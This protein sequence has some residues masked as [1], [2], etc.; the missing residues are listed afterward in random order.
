MSR[1]K[2]GDFV[3]IS[4]DSPL[5]GFKAG[6]RLKILG[7]PYQGTWLVECA[8]D[9]RASASPK[10]CTLMEESELK[11]LDKYSSSEPTVN[12]EAAQKIDEVAFITDSQEIEEALADSV[13]GE[14]RTIKYPSKTGTLS[15]AQ[16]RSAV[17]VVSE[18][19]SV[20]GIL[21]KDELSWPTTH[22]VAT[23]SPL[24]EVPLP[25]FPG[26]ENF[27]KW[28]TGNGTTGKNETPVGVKNDE[29]KPRAG[30]VLEGF[31]L[32]LKGV[33]ESGTLGAIEYGD[34]NWLIVP[35]AKK[36]FRDAMMRHYLEYARG[37]KIDP[38]SK[39]SHFKHFVWNALAVLHFEME[40]EEKIKDA[41]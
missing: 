18:S 4:R 9:S 26:W 30:L 8:C 41:M 32:A 1:F 17:K 33:V 12:S 29:G 6:D 2:A 27:E 3:T 34:D 16:I 24:P 22:E 28:W 11:S 13:D 35:D 31:A 7:S 38:K 37:V 23:P 25:P 40:E 19:R 36:R 15:K 39:I 10:W 21:G 5:K 20:E 14:F